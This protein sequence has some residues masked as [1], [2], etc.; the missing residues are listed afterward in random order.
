MVSDKDKLKKLQPNRT[1]AEI[2]KE[3]KIID[4]LRKRNM[5]RTITIGKIEKQAKS[6]LEKSGQHHPHLFIETKNGLEVYLLGFKSDDEKQKMMNTFR[7]MIS[8]RNV[9]SYFVVFEGWI[10]KQEPLGKI[11]RPRDDPNR[12]EVII[13]SQYNKDNTGQTI[14]QEFERKGK[15][16]VWGEKTTQKDFKEMR[17]MWNFYLEDAGEEAMMA[18]RWEAFKKEVPDYEESMN[19]Y[20][21]KIWNNMPKDINITK[22]EMK[23]Q[24]QK[25]AKKMVG[26]GR[27]YRE[28][29]ENGEKT[30]TS[31]QRGSK[32]KDKP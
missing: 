6:I 26:E 17:S 7:K 8:E 13:I 28:K 15:K 5:K 30:N 23:K 27:V 18:A 14:L 31:K 20:V 11:V 4:K 9:D 16:I 19:D 1:K 32:N 29:K 22:E 25:T 12:V 3:K 2:K 10:S 24:L 21:D